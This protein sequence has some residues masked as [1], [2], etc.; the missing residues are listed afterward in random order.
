MSVAY[1]TRQKA[2]PKNKSARPGTAA[3]PSREDGVYTA[4]SDKVTPKIEVNLRT[5]AT[6]KSDVAANIKNGT[7]LNRTGIG[8]NGWSKINYNGKTVYAITSYLTTDLS[9]KA[10]ESKPDDGF[11]AASGKV[12]AKDEW[13]NGLHQNKPAYNR[14]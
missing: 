11:A 13:A 6:T 7:V 5:A 10:P 2:E 8:S 1:F 9:A 3:A 14:G 4:V 12:T